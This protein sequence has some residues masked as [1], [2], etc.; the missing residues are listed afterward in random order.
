M[1]KLLISIII[2]LV[3]TTAYATCKA[4]EPPVIPDP[5]TTVT[6]EMVKAQNDVKAFLSAAERFLKCTKSTSRHNQM[7]DKMKNIGDDFN[8]TVKAYKT[9]M[10][11]A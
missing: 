2:F 8:N 6:A 3:N 10:A 7:V 1:N 11:N 4:P 9:R 5:E